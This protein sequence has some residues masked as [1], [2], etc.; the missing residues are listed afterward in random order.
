MSQKKKI[1]F[2]DD[3]VDFLQGQSTFFSGRGY[4]VLT[5]S[6]GD[7]AMKLLAK[8]TP[9]FIFLDLMMENYDSGFRL[10]HKIRREERFKN[11]PMVMLSGVAATAGRRFDQEMDG[12]KNWCQLDGF[13][14]KPVSGK[15][16]LDLVEKKTATA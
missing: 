11:I 15:Q 1:L 3:D 9:D 13:L 10:S 2:I 5:A 4:D 16:L 12:L 14:D 6:S 7:E 8:V